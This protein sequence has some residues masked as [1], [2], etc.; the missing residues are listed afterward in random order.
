MQQYKTYVIYAGYGHLYP[1]T[2]SG[3]IVC[4]F[5]SL[6]GVP[7]NAILIGSL[8]TFFTNIVS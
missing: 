6:L 4:I 5:Y 1:E 3:K 2:D 8:A 7:L